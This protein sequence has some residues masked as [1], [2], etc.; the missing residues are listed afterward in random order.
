MYLKHVLEQKDQ[1]NMHLNVCKILSPVSGLVH[2]SAYRG[3]NGVWYELYFIQAVKI[4]DSCHS[5]LGRHLMGQIQDQIDQN[6]FF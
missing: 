2:C 1:Q 4:G 6:I 3:K 5:L